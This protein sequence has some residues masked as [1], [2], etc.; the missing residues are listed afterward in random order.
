[1]RPLLTHSL[2]GN[3]GASL[4][5]VALRVWPISTL[6]PTNILCAPSDSTYV[7]QQVC[8][9]RGAQDLVGYTG[10]TQPE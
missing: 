1:M 2:I 5:L 9:V 10:A 7:G 8:D 3:R 6:I 4:E